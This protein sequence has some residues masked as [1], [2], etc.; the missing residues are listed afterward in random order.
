MSKLFWE[1]IL[2][3]AEKITLKTMNLK[4]ENLDKEKFNTIIKPKIFKPVLTTCF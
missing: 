1:T 2:L 4:H 3:C